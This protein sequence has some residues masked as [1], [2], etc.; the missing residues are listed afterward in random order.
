MIDYSLLTGVQRPYEGTGYASSIAVEHVR[1]RGIRLGPT[2]H[3]G[4]GRSW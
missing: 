1:S 2:Q 3:N 4:L